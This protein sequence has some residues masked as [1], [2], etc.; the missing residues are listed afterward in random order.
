[1]S[2]ISEKQQNKRTSIL[3]A[4]YELFIEKSVN[5]TSIDDV[6]KSAGIAKGTF[7]LYFKDKH[8]LMNRIII[9][10]G[11]LVLRYVLEELKIKKTQCV[12]TFTE[13]MLFITERI[14]DYLEKHKE[15]ITLMGK[16][17][18][19][20][21]SYFNSIEDNEL[22]SMLDELVKENIRKRYQN[23]K[24]PLVDEAIAL[25]AE[26]RQA[27]ADGEALKAERNKLSKA[28]G[29]LFGK[30]KK[31]TDEAEKAAIQAQ[32]DANNA[33][34]KADADRMAQMEEKKEHAEAALNKIMMVN[35]VSPGV[36][37]QMPTK[38]DKIFRKCLEVPVFG[39]LVYHMVVSRAAINNEFIENFAFDPF[40]P[41]RDLQDAYYEA[42]H[43][44]GCYAKNIYANKISK[45]MNIDIT[46]ALKEI[47]N[48]LYIVEGEAENNGEATVE[49][50]Q[51]I[52]PSVETV[53]LNETKHFPQVEDPEHFLEQVGIFF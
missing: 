33:A 45:Y 44:G 30:L 11:A 39:T 29:P 53:T 26:R 4:A 5:N 15:I 38:K 17:F 50:Y 12:M 1:M 9:R 49:A 16:N 23:A 36:L 24:L 52:N 31:C 46:R 41:L 6:V 27:I 42:A 2:K 13:Q 35:P 48:S 3:D 22:K 21:L 25:D 8:D 28:N 51:N 19:N 14:V 20:C 34:V 43:K 40:H 18:S 37:K 32:I 7:Y 10:K 47:D